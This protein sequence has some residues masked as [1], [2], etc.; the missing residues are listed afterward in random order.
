MIKKARDKYRGLPV[1]LEA[2]GDSALISSSCAAK[3]IAK[4]DFLILDRPS[5]H[6]GSDSRIGSV[7]SSFV[8]ALNTFGFFF[9]KDHREKKAGQEVPN[10]IGMPELMATFRPLKKNLKQ[11]QSIAFLPKDDPTIQESLK[12]V[13]EGNVDE[14]R[15]FDDHSNSSDYKKY[16]MEEQQLI[17]L[18][19]WMIMKL[20]QKPVTVVSSF[21]RF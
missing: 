6:S 10:Y 21:V 3:R 11:I 19:K 9:S 8:P 18:K 2:L 13:L 4:I 17:Q 14:I 16:P 12:R 20:I 7:F 15:L 5:F 1:F